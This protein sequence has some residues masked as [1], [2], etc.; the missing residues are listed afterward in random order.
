MRAGKHFYPLVSLVMALLAAAPLAGQELAPGDAA[1]WKAFAPREQN[2][3]AAQAAARAG[4]GY[5]LKLAA[6]GKAHA[7]GGWR[8]RI[9]GIDPGAFYRF[10]ARAVARDV[11]DPGESVG[12]QLRWRGDYG[13]AVA[14]TYVWNSRGKGPAGTLEFDRVVEAP[15]KTRAVEVELVLQW[16]ATGQVAWEDVS[17]TRAA[18]PAPRKVRVATVWLRPRGSRNGLESVERFAEYVERVAAEHHPDVILLGEMINRVGARG[19]LDEQAEPIPG[20]TTERMG[21]QARRSRAWI[22]FSMVEREGRD[23]FN[24]GVLLDRQGRIAGKY[25]KVQLPFEEV[26]RGISPGSGFPVFTTDFGRVGM[27]ICHDASFPQAAREL[28]LN[29]A[30]LILMPIWGGRQTLIRARAMENGVYL[31][32]SG[33]DYESEIIDPVG[34]V[35]ASAAKEKGPAV[36]VADLD[37]SKRF[38]EDWIGDWNDTLNRQQRPSAY[39]K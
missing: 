15:P 23:I 12:V 19:E 22:A 3:P 39:Q 1:A 7:Y 32:T 31:A 18:A 34:R 14:P 2:A 13:E 24:T 36:A 8:T 35:L 30:E 10:R 9:E 37:L 28:A 26:S 27:L 4:G 16:T 33:Y 21:E 38:R 6:G 25:R 11:A 5:S 20:P 29:G 17:L